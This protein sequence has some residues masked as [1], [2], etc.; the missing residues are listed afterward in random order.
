LFPLGRRT[1]GTGPPNLNLGPHNISESTRAGMWKLKTQLNIVMYSIW[2][3]NISARERP[4]RP[5][6]AW[7]PSVNFGP[8]KSRKLLEL[9]S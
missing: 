3:Q 1:G 5:G 2:V 6:S 7:P 4:R 8:L 9:E